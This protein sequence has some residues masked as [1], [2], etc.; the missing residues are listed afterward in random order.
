[1]TLRDIEHLGY[2]MVRFERSSLARLKCQLVVLQRV[3][4][5][6]PF[7]SRLFCVFVSTQCTLQMWACCVRRSCGPSM[8]IWREL[9]RMSVRARALDEFC[10]PVSDADSPLRA[11]SQ[12][13]RCCAA[14][15]PATP[16]SSMEPEHV[17]RHAHRCKT[18]FRLAHCSPSFMT[19]ST[20]CVTSWSPAPATCD[21]FAPMSTRG[22]SCSMT[23]SCCAS[24]GTAVCWRPHRHGGKVSLMTDSASLCRVVRGVVPVR[25]MTCRRRRREGRHALAPAQALLVFDD[26]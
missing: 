16:A 1:M 4:H 10:G 11:T 8:G 23:T 5:L 12:R 21:A 13:C 20:N 18:Q 14:Q 26:N 3:R 6:P 9:K 19:S 25:Q 17:S 7:S 15:R 24:A 2:R 22:H